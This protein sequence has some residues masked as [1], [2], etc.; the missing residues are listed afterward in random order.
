MYIAWNFSFD[1]T[2]RELG[3]IVSPNK[4]QLSRT[5]LSSILLQSMIVL[6]IVVVLATLRTL[7]SIR[8]AEIR[9]AAVKGA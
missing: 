5:M 1:A 7:G 3:W 6:Y 4:G 9:N 8:K 2:G